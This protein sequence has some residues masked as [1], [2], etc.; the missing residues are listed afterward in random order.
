[1]VVMLM[2]FS[3]L[4]SAVYF[5]LVNRSSELGF[6]LKSLKCIKTDVA[7]IASA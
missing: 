6:D 5:F 3:H 1:M 2:A 7:E 4:G